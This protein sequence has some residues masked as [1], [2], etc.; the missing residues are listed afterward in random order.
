MNQKEANII[1]SLGN[2]PTNCLRQYNSPPTD[3]R[4]GG[5]S[6]WLTTVLPQAVPH[7]E[8]EVHHI[9]ILVAMRE[10]RKCHWKVIA[11]RQKQ[12]FVSKSFEKYRFLGRDAQLNIPFFIGSIT[13]RLV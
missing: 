9:S 8:N 10:P 11:R 5:W 13:I 4:A 3:H 6:G 2:F 1:A 7:G 12:F